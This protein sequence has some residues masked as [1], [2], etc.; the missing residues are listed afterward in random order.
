M[1]RTTKITATALAA[2]ALVLGACSSGDDDTSESSGSDDLT[3]QETEDSMVEEFVDE[4]EAGEI[5]EGSTGPEPDLV[6]ESASAV[7]NVS[8][9]CI[10]GE[11]GQVTFNL[12]GEVE[13]AEETD[14]LNIEVGTQ[15]TMLPVGAGLQVHQGSIPPGTTISV[16]FPDGTVEGVLEEGCA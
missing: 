16:E 1:P 8:L 3:S 14:I 4:A 12:E 11:Q 15:S 7:L 10:E 2:A 9:D 5:G 6:L 13:G